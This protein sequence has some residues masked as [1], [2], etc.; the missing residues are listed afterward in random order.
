MYII[1]PVI[2]NGPQDATVCMNTKTEFNCGFLGANPLHVV[3]DWRIVSRSEN[4]SVISNVTHDGVDI[5]HKRI[6]G[7]RWSP[8]LTSGYNNA[9][10]SKLLVG[11]V[12]K[13]HN[14]SSYQCV[15]ESISGSIV[16]SVGTLT[17]VGEAIIFVYIDCNN[18]S[19]GFM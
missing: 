16:S 15:I 18:V 10:N 17:V 9:T 3:P 6:N 2:I 5:A 1:G 12:N 13:T 4:G 7:L 11:P 14:Q 8:D 19:M